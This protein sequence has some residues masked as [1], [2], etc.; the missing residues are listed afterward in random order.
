MDI[1]T[2]DFHTEVC[3]IRDKEKMGCMIP[4]RI[5][6]TAMCLFLLILQL[7]F[8]SVRAQANGQFDVLVDPL[9]S[10]LF[11]VYGLNTNTSLDS[12]VW[13]VNGWQGWQCTKDGFMS[14]DDGFGQLR[15][16]RYS[17]NVY[18]GI[19]EDIEDFYHP[20]YGTREI[21]NSLNVYISETN[22][23]EEVAK[24]IMHRA[25]N[26]ITYLKGPATSHYIGQY[27]E[28]YTWDIPGSRYELIINMY[29]IIFAGKTEISIVR[30]KF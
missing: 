27:S 20:T 21:K 25:V 17:R 23:Q 15:W 19:D 24:Q 22:V 13:T 9:T 5:F 1:F 12:F 29:T 3:S 6:F 4:K 8:S 26:N 11:N 30:K 7:S 18:P 28:S 2:N 16:I 14:F 10:D